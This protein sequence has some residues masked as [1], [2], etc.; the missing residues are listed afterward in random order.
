MENVGM[1]TVGYAVRRETTRAVREAD[2]VMDGV[3]RALDLVVACAALVCFLPFMVLIVI[4]VF[5]GDGGPVVYSQRRIG[6][7]GKEFS[8]L[9]F[10]SMVTDSEERLARLLASDPEARAE[11]N[12]NQK[13]RHD[14]RITPIGRLLRKSSF[15]ELPQIVNVLMGH[16]SVVGPRPIVRDEVVRY[17][18]YFDHYCAQR[19]GITGLWQISG[20]SNTDYRRRV[21][22]DVAYCRSKSPMLD[23]RIVVMTIPAILLSRGAY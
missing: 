23:M 8:C 7:D 15:D 2:P 10:R 13:L 5:V 11:W 6:K 22:L 16:M 18:R 20:R 1:S 14:P 3:G 4:A 12:L 17:G 19:P 21:A 9:K